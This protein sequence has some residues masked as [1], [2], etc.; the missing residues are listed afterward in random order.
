[1][2]TIEEWRKYREHAVSDFQGDLALVAMHSIEGPTQVPGI[3]GLWKP[4]AADQTGLSLTASARDGITVDG[5]LVE[6]TVTLEADRSIVRFSETLTATATH[7]PGSNHLLAIYDA[8][9]DAI[10]RFGGISSYPENP[11]WVVEAEFVSE[12]RDRMVAFAHKSD[13]SGTVRHHE[14]PGD[15]QF[16][17]DGVSYRLSPFA[18]DGS[19]VIVFGDKTNGKETY[20]MG[21]MLVVSIDAENKVILDFNRAILPPCAFSYHFNCPLPPAHN[22]L[23]FEVTAGE[24]QVVHRAV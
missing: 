22:R 18:S 16:T 4:L 12:D 23:P 19:L 17:M 9:A 10:A 5:Q 20:G 8:K 3:P 15:I 11:E 13:Q 14:S 6:G 1:M 24:K 7:Q 21:R 2:S